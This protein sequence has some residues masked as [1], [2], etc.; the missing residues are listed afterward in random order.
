[1]Q[2][3]SEG[4]QGIGDLIDAGVRDGLLARQCAAGGGN[5]GAA[6][7]A[8]Q[9]STAAAAVVMNAAN[10]SGA[11][12][13]H[14]RACNRMVSNASKLAA[15]V[16]ASVAGSEAGLITSD[17]QRAVHLS[18]AGRGA[19]LRAAGVWWIAVTLITLPSRGQAD[20]GCDCRRCWLENRCPCCGAGWPGSAG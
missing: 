1:M 12:S 17:L 19:R 18:S 7:M 10:S 14:W 11:R 2:H 3:R 20:A 13:S 8:S 6:V 4:G 9:P 15:S 16:S 5:D